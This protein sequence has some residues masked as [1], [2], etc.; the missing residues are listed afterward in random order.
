VTPLQTAL[1]AKA[2]RA[3]AAARRMLDHDPDTT[4]NRAY[5][6]CFDAARAAL[7]GEGDEP[8]THSGVHN[9]FA[10]RFVATGRIQEDVARALSYAAQV[11][12]RAD[13]NALT[14]LDART[15]ADLLADAVQFVAAV[16]A[17]VAEQGGQP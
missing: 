17:L 13:Y 14:V 15:A 11:R 8:K 6:A 1:F 3:L 16:Q 12:E 5:Y 2:D 9:R 4:A 7:L 10:L